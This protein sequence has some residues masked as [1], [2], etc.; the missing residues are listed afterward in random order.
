MT[1]KDL[2]VEENWGKKTFEAHPNWKMKQL[3]AEV[4]PP[5]CVVN[6]N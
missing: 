1:I 3:D 4:S 6:L 5:A 2:G